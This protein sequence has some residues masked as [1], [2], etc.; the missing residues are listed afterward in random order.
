[1]PLGSP[2]QDLD[3]QGPATRTETADFGWCNIDPTVAGDLAD[4]L[5]KIGGM[6]VVCYINDI[7]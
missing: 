6:E 2:S 1:V 7:G 5:V 4:A 3:S